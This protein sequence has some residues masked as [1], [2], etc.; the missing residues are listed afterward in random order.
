MTTEISSGNWLGDSRI[1]ILFE[2]RQTVYV[3]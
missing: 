3:R 2:Q 1:Y